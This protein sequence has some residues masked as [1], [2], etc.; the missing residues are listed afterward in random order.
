M[1][2]RA[3]TS[4]YICG[5]CTY[6]VTPI[7]SPDVAIARNYLITFTLIMRM[8]SSTRGGLCA[9]SVMTNHTLS[10][11]TRPIDPHIFMHYNYTS[12]HSVPFT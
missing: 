3:P 8:Q 6:I 7:L 12:A 9:S 4:R 5:I 10:Q 11:D 1:C 2:M